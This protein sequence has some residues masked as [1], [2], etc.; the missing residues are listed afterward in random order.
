M[1]NMPSYDDPL[2][3][4]ELYSDPIAVLEIA[5]PGPAGPSGPTG[6]SG[7]PG[8]TGPTGAR[9]WDFQ[10]TWSP[11][12]QYDADDAVSWHG[13]LYYTNGEA[14]VGVVPSDDH[15]QTVRS[16]WFLVAR[17]VVE[18]SG[19]TDSEA[20]MVFSGDVPAGVNPVV[21]HWLGTMNITSQVFE[22]EDNS[23]VLA[24]VTPIDDN[25][26]RVWVASDEI[27][28]VDGTYTVTVLT[29]V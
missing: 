28:P 26:I 25:S 13:S 7:P 19:G 6:P 22:K 16:G 18:A 27:N 12:T 20:P 17:I 2:N 1:P 15:G 5:T 10:G 29:G 23:T 21:F 3:F 14:E 11:D 8:L 24:K 4:I 9:A